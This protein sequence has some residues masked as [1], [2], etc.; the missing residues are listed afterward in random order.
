MRLQIF[1]TLIGFVLAGFLS[2]PA[3]AR[4]LCFDEEIDEDA[5]YEVEVGWGRPSLLD[6][7]PEPVVA[8]VDAP[9]LLA[10]L[11]AL[12]KDWKTP[13]GVWPES[14][15]TIEIYERGLLTCQAI[16]T[17]DFIFAMDE[18]MNGFLVRGLAVAEYFALNEA[19]GLDNFA[20]PVE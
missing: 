8:T 11:R 18:D 6:P 5:R 4:G 13:T 7:D 10:A 14:A 12:E 20:R 3:A 2:G 19:L 15:V 1:Q 17:R 9:A 16:Y